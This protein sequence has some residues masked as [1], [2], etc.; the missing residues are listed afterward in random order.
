M[1]FGALV[2]QFEPL[3]FWQILSLLSGKVVGWRIIIIVLP[4]PGFSLYASE[5]TVVSL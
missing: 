3:L 4:E 5:N 2:A 1:A